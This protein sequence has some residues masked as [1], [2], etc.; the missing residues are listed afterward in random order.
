MLKRVKDHV[1][2]LANLFSKI[3]RGELTQQT[4]FDAVSRC[5]SAVRDVIAPS[6]EI[7]QAESELLAT[8]EMYT[9]GGR[10]EPSVALLSTSGSRKRIKQQAAEALARYRTAVDAA[11]SDG[12]RPQGNG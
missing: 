9:F 5:T 7:E 8:A 2:D 1:D 12:N 4:W 10:Q 3:E 6:P 11:A